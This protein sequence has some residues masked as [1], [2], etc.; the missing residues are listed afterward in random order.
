MEQ[1][2]ELLLLGI[3]FDT[4]K[5]SSVP[6]PALGDVAP[7]LGLLDIHSLSFIGRMIYPL[8]ELFSSFEIRHV[9]AIHL[10][11]FPGLW[12]SPHAWGMIIQAKAAKSSKLNAPPA[13]QCDGHGIQNHFN[14]KLDILSEQLRV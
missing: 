3:E 10:H 5:L 7:F 13:C 6:I 14:D 8:P 2:D 1:E 9:F 4:M 12:I 11:F